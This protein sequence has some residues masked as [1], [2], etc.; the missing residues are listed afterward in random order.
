ME[1]NI[2]FPAANL[3]EEDEILI[4]ENDDYILSK[5]EKLEIKNQ[6]KENLSTPKDVLENHDR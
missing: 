4:I 3:S 2:N 6:E 5:A 1:D